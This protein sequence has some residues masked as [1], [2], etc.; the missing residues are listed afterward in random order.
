[1]YTPKFI[2]QEGKYTQGG[3]FMFE[4]QEYIGYY[5]VTA[6]GYYTDKTFTDRSK[7]LYPLEYSLN[8]VSQKYLELADDRGIVTDQEFDDPIFYRPVIT[9]GDKKRGFIVRYFIQQRNDNAGRIREIDKDQ[10]EL[11]G[12]TSA[13]LNPSYYKSVELKWKISG[14]EHDV[15]DGDI[16]VTPGIRDTNRRTLKEKSVTLSGLD[17]LLQ[18]RLAQFSEFDLTD[19]RTN[20]DIRL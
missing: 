12:D 16:I 6:D 13:G 4:G 20:T 18:N 5:N 17:I 9:D 14:L 1:M 10:Y 3:K 2:A 8:E 11:L 15:R 7:K 19:S